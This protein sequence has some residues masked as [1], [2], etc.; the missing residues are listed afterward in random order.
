MHHRRRAFARVRALSLALA[1]VAAAA[2]AVALWMASPSRN[3]GAGEARAP[4]GR[5][6][7]AIVFCADPNNMPFSNARGEGFE[8][9]IAEI[10]AQEMGRPLAYRWAPQRRGFIR[11][12]LNA[13]ECDV[14][15]GI[16][17]TVDMLLTTRPYYRSTYVFVTRRGSSKIASFDDPRLRRLRI[18][19]HLIGD[20]G[21]NSTP[22]H[23]L[24]QRGIIGNLV[25]FTVYGNYAEPNPPARLVEAVAKGDID[26][27]IAWGPLAGWV[28]QRSP[29]PL[30]LVPVSP[31]IDLP[32]LP[33][34][35]DIAMGV[36]RTD[37]LLR[38]TLEA[39]LVRRRA[40]ID[41]VLHAYGVPL[42][43]R[44]YRRSDG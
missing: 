7:S 11:T 12:T 40:G 41:S 38:D 34:V 19:V 26:V 20:D 2:V 37:T 14:I 9:R 3:A 42:A 10:L 17:S 32:F 8:N 23:A 30:D 1:P 28:A 21:A 6:D 39:I 29:V 24:T 35:F 13:R 4:A 43:G 5:A 27:A 18:G 33:H 15:A 31:Q 36:R 44:T 22:V 16:P 25:G